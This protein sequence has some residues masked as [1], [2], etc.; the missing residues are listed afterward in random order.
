MA[1][2]VVSENVSVL[3]DEFFKP[4]KPFD[5]NLTIIAK[6]TET[7]DWFVYYVVDGIAALFSFAVSED[8]TWFDAMSA[9]LKDWGCYA[10][11]SDKLLNLIGYEWTKN[12][13]SLGKEV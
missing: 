8:N 12:V 1:T 3:M 2:L 5:V 7:G 11:E 13:Y 4:A 10:F 6:K 9:E